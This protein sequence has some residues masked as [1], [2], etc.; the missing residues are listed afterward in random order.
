MTRISLVCN[1]HTNESPVTRI[2]AKK[3]AATLRLRN[4]DA[5]IVSIPDVH[6]L[7]G[8]YRDSPVNS[9]KPDEWISAFRKKNP[10]SFV[11]ELHTTPD[12]DMLVPLAGKSRNLKKIKNWQ[13]ASGLWLEA[14]GNIELLQIDRKHCVIEMPAAYVQNPHFTSAH[15][16]GISPNDAK[17]FSRQADA[18]Q[19]QRKNYLDR[20]VVQRMAHLIDSEVKTVEKRYRT[21]RLPSHLRRMP[22]ELQKQRF[23]LAKAMRRQR[24]NPRG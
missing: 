20:L 14:R 22:K 1:F 2:L 21:P 11:V 12:T 3:L 23:E 15:R 13:A 18:A 7:Q 8:G 6:S 19:S 5:E 16:L 17:Y 24:I 10:D 9:D 4:L